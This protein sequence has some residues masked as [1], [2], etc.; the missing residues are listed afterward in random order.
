M[1]SILLFPFLVVV[2]NQLLENT[3]GNHHSAAY[4]QER[5]GQSACKWLAA[6]SPYNQAPLFLSNTLAATKEDAGSA[7]IYLLIFCHFN[8][9]IFLINHFGL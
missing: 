8:S 4:H 5:T 6:W 3:A 1:F 2:M 9:S 7:Y